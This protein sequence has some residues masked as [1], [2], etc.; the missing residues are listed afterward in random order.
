MAAQEI[1]L[2]TF[3]RDIAKMRDRLGTPIV[4]DKDLGGYRLE[5]SPD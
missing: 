1:S 3:K 2:A 4:F 5:A